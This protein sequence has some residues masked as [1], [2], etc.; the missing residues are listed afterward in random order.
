LRR[1]SL[2]LTGPRT[3]EWVA[4]DLSPLQA[5]EI[6]VRTTSGAMSLGTELARYRGGH[7]AAE[8]PSYPLMTGYENVGSVIERTAEVSSIPIGQRVVASYGHRSHAVLDARRA[9]PV[10]DDIP[11]SLALLSILSC[12]V[13]KGLRKL[14]PQPDQA[15]LITGMGVMG[16][17][18]L[19]MLRVRGLTRIDVI[20]PLPR[21]REL[22]IRLGARTAITPAETPPEIAYPLAV[23]CSDR[24]AAF[25]MLQRAM[26]QHGRICVLADG[27][28]E[29]LTLL[30]E[31]HTKEL[32]IAGSSDG[33]DYAA[34]AAWFW[35]YLRQHKP[36]LDALFDVHIT[37][38]ALP[39]T[40]AALN[41]GMLSAIKV[42]IAY[43]E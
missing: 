12:D 3:L 16:L 25:H 22:A 23:E 31:F 7:H 33:W 42:L 15:V 5:H 32:W 18:T 10:P 1:K 43:E 24:D 11:D 34:H 29:P 38:D 40:F 19:A 30:P 26:Q 14:Q 27:N 9:I 17:L 41:E 20:D 21:R 13:E 2:L 28:I 39:A 36:P 4:E 8:A 35:E 6:L 37:A